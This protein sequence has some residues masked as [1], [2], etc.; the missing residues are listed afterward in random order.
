MLYRALAVPDLTGT[1]YSTLMRFQ[2][3]WSFLLWRDDDRVLLRSQTKGP[4]PHYL[5]DEML[6]LVAVMQNGLAAGLTKHAI[7]GLFRA[8]YGLP[9]PE[10]PA[11][12]PE[13]IRRPHARDNLFALGDPRGYG[14]GFEVV[15]F[16]PQAERIE[17]GHRNLAVDFS[18]S[19]VLLPLG[20][21]ADR[22]SDVQTVATD[23]GEAR[24]I[25]PELK[26]QIQAELASRFEAFCTG[27]G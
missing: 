20:A 23:A 12:W 17:L 25:P 4:V 24:I 5:L 6:L 11:D 26:D 2:Q 21:I 22:L 19:A 9:V 27:D 16:Y 7:G 13:D 3:A 1:P 14:T 18:Q 8:L 10:V 15:A